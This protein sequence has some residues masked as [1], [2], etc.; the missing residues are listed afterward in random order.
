M[1]ISGENVGWAHVPTRNGVEMGDEPRGQRYA[2]A[3]PTKI[4][5]VPWQ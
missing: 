4:G 1:G 5:G 3:H 2:F